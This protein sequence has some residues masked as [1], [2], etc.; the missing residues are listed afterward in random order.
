VNKTKLISQ[1]DKVN[2]SITLTTK[3]QSVK[4]GVDQLA[5]HPSSSQV[6]LE[7][8][9]EKQPLKQLTLLDPQEENQIYFNEETQPHERLQ[10]ESVPSS[11]LSAATKSSKGSS[12]GIQI[13]HHQQ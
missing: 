6:S 3:S 5:V 2:T 4:L 13:K 12:A 7:E 10:R 8:M 1:N 9:S 11:R